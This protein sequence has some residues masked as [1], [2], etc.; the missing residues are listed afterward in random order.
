MQEAAFRSAVVFTEA[1]YDGTV[2]VVVDADVHPKTKTRVCVPNL[3]NQEADRS[4]E[5]AK[6]FVP[7]DRSLERR[8]ESDAEKGQHVSGRIERRVDDQLH[9][10]RDGQELR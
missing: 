4:S 2:I 3:S 9:I 1:S 7:F 10:R 8:S 6:S 5:R